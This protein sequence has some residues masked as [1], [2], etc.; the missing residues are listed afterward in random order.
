MS[1]FPV[2]FLEGFLLAQNVSCFPGAESHREIR[3]HSAKTRVN[4]GA[5]GFPTLATFP[6][7]ETLS[8]LWVS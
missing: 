7:Q 5:I 2:S 3:K 1:G 8:F 6:S 4:T